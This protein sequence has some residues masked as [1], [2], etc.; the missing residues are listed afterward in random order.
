MSVAGDSTRSPVAVDEGRDGAL[1]TTMV[2]SPAPGFRLTELSA[3][4]DLRKFFALF[5]GQPLLDRSKQIIRSITIEVLAR[6]DHLDT[7]GAENVSV[8]PRFI[9]IDS[10]ESLDVVDDHE[11]KIT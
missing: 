6:V 4:D 10:P 8:I 3:D 11:S 9:V 1:D 2:E 5:S 7:F